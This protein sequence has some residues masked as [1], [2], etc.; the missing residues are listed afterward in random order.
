MK[1]TIF[2]TNQVRHIYLVNLLSKIAD[3][4]FYI[5][6]CNTI[7]PGKHKDFYNNS[8]IMKTYFSKV[9]DSERKVFGELVF[10]KKNIKTLSLRW[11]DL[12][13]LELNQLQ[14]AFDSDLYIVFGASYIKGWLVEK[15]I[16]KNAINIHMGLSPYYR[17]SSCNFW[18]V[19]DK[20]YGHVGATVHYLSKGLDSGKILFHCVPQL[21]IGDSL[22]DYT[23]RAAKTV[24][25][26]LFSKIKT[27][28]IFTLKAK[29]QNKQLEVRYTKNIDFTDKIAKEFLSRKI[30][31]KKDNITYPNLYNFN[32]MNNKNENSF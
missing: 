4:I 29:E 26:S 27:K 9:L 1:I 21:L 22:F 12:N 25:D 5:K 17:G 2:S 24:Q 30:V 7:F 14:E 8:D 28:E 13:S 11:N 31:I 23:M 32:N 15:L 10:T 16:S 20:N 19:Y 18:A 3:E 6:E